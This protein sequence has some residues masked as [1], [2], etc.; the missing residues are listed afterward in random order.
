MTWIQSYQW[1]IFLVLGESCKA[2]GN[3]HRITMNTGRESRKLHDTWAHSKCWLT[4]PPH[5]SLLPSKLSLIISDVQ[6]TA[7]F[8]GSLKHPQTHFLA[9][10][11]PSTPTLLIFPLLPAVP[12]FLDLSSLLP[13]VPQHR[14]RVCKTIAKTLFHTLLPISSSPGPHLV[15]FLLIINTDKM[16]STAWKS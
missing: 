7:W 11:F 2:R 5:F 16:K 8:T 13:A 3:L 14:D 9:F 15:Y 4:A 6:F 1:L 12:L 10:C